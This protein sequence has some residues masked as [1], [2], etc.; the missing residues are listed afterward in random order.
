MIPEF[1]DM[2]VILAHLHLPF[3][4]RSLITISATFQTMGMRIP[5]IPAL[6]MIRFYDYDL[7]VTFVE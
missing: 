1:C 6:P 4:V 3:I 2:S 5:G 7:E